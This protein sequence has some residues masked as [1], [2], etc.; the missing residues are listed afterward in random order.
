MTVEL[1]LMHVSYARAGIPMD[2]GLGPESTR[3]SRNALKTEVTIALDVL[4][5]IGMYTQ[6]PI[7]RAMIDQCSAD[8]HYTDNH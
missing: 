6:Y 7:E 3:Y 8:Q 2:A 1:L 5:L 4:T